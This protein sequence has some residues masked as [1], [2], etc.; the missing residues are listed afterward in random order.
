MQNEI[1]DDRT[2]ANTVLELM[3]IFDK[4]SQLHSAVMKSCVKRDKDGFQ[5]SSKERTRL[6]ERRYVVL[7][8]LNDPTYLRSG[9][10]CSAMDD[11]HWFFVAAVLFL[12]ENL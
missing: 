2:R 10:K 5:R 9:S 1:L 7:E 11:L 4:S 6:A 12:K 3:A 8:A